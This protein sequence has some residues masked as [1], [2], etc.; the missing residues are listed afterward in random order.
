MKSLKKIEKEKIKPEMI[1]KIKS[2]A[3]RLI[4]KKEEQIDFY[5]K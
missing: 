3:S 4:D 2:I 5:I 1:L